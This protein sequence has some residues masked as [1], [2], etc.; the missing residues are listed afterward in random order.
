MAW[1]PSTGAGTFTAKVGTLP[2]TVAWGTDG[3]Y[4]GVILV[5][6][7]S[8]LMTEEI[9]IENGTGLTATLIGLNDGTEVILT[10][11]DDRSVTFPDWMSTLSLIDPRPTGAGGTTTTFQVLNNNYKTGRKQEG[12]RSLHC[13]KFTLITPS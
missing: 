10:A 9:K 2:T 5:S 8:N 1:P 4:A 7:E 12:Q 13:K 3:I 6:C 11:I